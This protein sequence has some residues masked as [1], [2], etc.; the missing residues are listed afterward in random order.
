MPNRFKPNR[1]NLPFRA[2]A[3]AIATTTPIFTVT[4]E[5]ELTVTFP[6]G[7][8]G[9]PSDVT[10]FFVI[11][12]GAAYVFDSQVQ[13]IVPGQPNVWDVSPYFA[14]AIKAIW[15]AQPNGYRSPQ[16]GLIDPAPTLLP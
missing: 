4:D 8:V 7:I 16:G 12:D 14:A 6:Q 10:V 2:K 5:S 13:P 1:K 3:V 15:I 11:D 9:E